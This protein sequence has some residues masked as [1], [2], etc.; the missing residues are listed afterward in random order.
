MQ[1]A[2]SSRTLQK[3]S[4]DNYTTIICFLEAFGILVC[5]EHCTAVVNLDVHL[6][7][8]HATP[9]AVRKQVI[10]QLSHF[11][12]TAPGA[13]ELPEQPAW[14]IE[15]LGTPRDGFNV[16]RASSSL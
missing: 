5:K 1:S 9:A 16:R 3:L 10:Q 13:V 12:T 14:P 6:R 2:R 15:E 11:P 8:Q 4:L 7:D